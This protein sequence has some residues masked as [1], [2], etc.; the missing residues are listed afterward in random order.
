MP[1]NQIRY[2]DDDVVGTARR[3]VGSTTYVGRMPDTERR[4]AL[5]NTD[6][7]SSPREWGAQ[8]MLPARRNK[9]M[10][11]PKNRPGGAS[12][13]LFGVLLAACGSLTY[14]TPLACTVPASGGLTQHVHSQG[15]IWYVLSHMHH[16]PPF[17][18]SFDSPL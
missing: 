11:K 17:L 4:E 1:A 9:A 15:R 14:C 6:K 13:S 8:Q 16:T 12:T 3:G 5:R 18:H 2:I 10:R 7:H